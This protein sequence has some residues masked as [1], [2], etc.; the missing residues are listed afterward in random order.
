MK[1]LMLPGQAAAPQGPVDVSMMYVMHHAF[2]RDLASFATA[3]PRTPL[4]DVVAWRAMRR[5]WELFSEALHHHH[6]GEDT[7]L[8]PALMERADAGEQA[9][10]VAMEA[11]HAEIDPLLATCG[12]SL[13][14][15]AAGTAGTDERAALAVRLVAAREGLGRHL[16]HE[17]IDAIAIIQRHLDQRTWEAIDARFAEGVP[18]RRLLALVPWAVYRL[19][20]AELH[21]V[22]AQ[23]RPAQRAVWRLTRRRFARLD[24]R[25][26]RHAGTSERAQKP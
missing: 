2:R 5:R 19:P 15:L 6:Q 10:L 7:W 18:P 25:A 1:P 4:E 16:A 20:S 13:S 22:L 9:T 12:A 21:R 17:E 3:A 8:W 26:F 11:E 23:G 14:K 24:R